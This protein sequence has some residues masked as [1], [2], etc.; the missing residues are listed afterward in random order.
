MKTICTLF[1]TATLLSTLA[2][3][4]TSQ[5]RVVEKRDT[6]LTI[7]ELEALH[8]ARLDSARMRFTPADVRF[9][10]GMISHHAQALILAG[11]T[12]A[13]GVSPAVKTLSARIINAQ[14]DEI[15][16]MQ[17]WLRLRGQ[18]VPEI[19]IE[20]LQ[21]T[22]TGVENMQEMMRGMPGMLSPDQLQ[23]LSQTTGDE[24]DRLFLTYMIEHHQGAVTMV[25]RL[26]NT[27]GAAQD[28]DVFRLASDI[29]VDQITEINFMDLL[30]TELAQAARLENN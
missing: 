20:G 6:P 26:F 30:L 27:D 3:E 13:N 16:T 11:L 5:V 22:V 15:A 29:Q 10:T 8:Q 19:H 18:P 12:P 28:E 2:H 9:I 4:A 17:R 23:R 7:E 24:Y 1:A 25:N 21:L 14:K